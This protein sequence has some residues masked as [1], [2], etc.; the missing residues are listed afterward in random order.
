MVADTQQS[1]A[2]AAHFNSAVYIA[3]SRFRLEPDPPSKFLPL[4][5]KKTAAIVSLGWIRGIS[6]CQAARFHQRLH[7][8]DSSVSI[9]SNH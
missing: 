6:S 9:L 3:L 7:P 5:S 2:H 8:M 1:S 4:Q